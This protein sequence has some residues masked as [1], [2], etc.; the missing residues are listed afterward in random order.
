MASMS[1][2]YSNEDYQAINDRL[3]QL[4]EA[5]AALDK[6]Q[7]AGINCAEWPDMCQQLIDRYGAL[8]ASYFPNRP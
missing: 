3:R 4:T 2:P 5:K 7:G 1:E 6:A 8:K